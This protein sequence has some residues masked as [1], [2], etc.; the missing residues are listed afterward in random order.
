MPHW[1]ENLFWI[2][3][4][5]NI[6]YQSL[7]IRAHY[8]NQKLAVLENF[9]SEDTG[10]LLA[11]EIVHVFWF[12]GVFLVNY[13][14]NKKSWLNNQY[15]ASSQGLNLFLKSSSNAGTGTVEYTQRCVKT[16]QSTLL[17]MSPTG[18]VHLNNK[19]TT[20]KYGSAPEGLNIIC[21]TPQLFIQKKP[22]ELNQETVGTLL[23]CMLKTGLYSH[24]K[25][26]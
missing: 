7:D 5:I 22:A 20:M 16:V 10:L 19:N 15:F 25:I 13:S 26:H 9:S 23:N 1:L 14:E 24:F 2:S 4:K 6:S 18:A 12:V 21:T 17:E 11:S 3:I 8:R